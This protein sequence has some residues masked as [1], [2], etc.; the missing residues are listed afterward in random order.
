[1]Q[2]EVSQ[3]FTKRAV[4][5]RVPIAMV[6]IAVVGHLVLLL[7][8]RMA[9]ITLSEPGASLT[10]LSLLTCASAMVLTIPIGVRLIRNP[11]SRSWW[12]IAPAALIVAAQV[13][14]A[15]WWPAVPSVSL[16]T[17]IMA[18]FGAAVALTCS[19]IVLLIHAKV[20]SRRLFVRRAALPLVAGLTGLVVVTAGAL[21]GLPVW[22]L[23][24]P[25]ALLGVMAVSI[26]AGLSRGSAGPRGDVVMSDAILIAW[27]S[28]AAIA[29]TS[30]ASGALSFAHDLS[31]LPPLNE[32]SSSRVVHLS[33][34]YSIPLVGAV[35]AGFAHRPVQVGMAAMGSGLD[36]LGTVGFLVVGLVIC[37]SHVRAALNQSASLLSK[38]SG[39][40]TPA[41]RPTVHHAVTA[42]EPSH[43]APREEKIPT[44]DSVGPPRAVA[45]ASA[46][47]AYNPLPV[48][49]G[50]APPAA[51][52]SPP[53]TLVTPIAGV[54]APIIE[55]GSIRVGRPI[56][57][58]SLPEEAAIA[59]LERGLPRFQRCY[60]SLSG[61]QPKVG[62]TLYFMIDRRGSVVDV[63]LRDSNASKQLEKCLTVQLFRSGFARPREDNARVTASM[64]FSP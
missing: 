53:E 32:A 6:V 33:W 57:E 61:P 60:D 44:P 55:R 35:V 47:G 22:L 48:G 38:Q 49:S 20:S 28:L 26:T 50:N 62:T 46:F 59:G 58:G 17:A 36:L 51:P 1:M 64:E 15:I 3:P 56:V 25:S 39:R 27:I 18:T 7:L 42:P 52:G 40:V 2:R 14:R 10:D 41:H 24:M 63:Q 4:D 9:I 21:Q 29:L 8:G 12:V 45:L 30:V 5:H 23:A 43:V 37:N 16:S 34:L 31:G 19:A 13:S 54:E 11:N